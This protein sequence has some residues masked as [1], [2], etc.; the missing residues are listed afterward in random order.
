[1]ETEKI[2][3]GGNTPDPSTDTTINNVVN[4]HATPTGSTSPAIDHSQAELTKV[5][6]SLNIYFFTIIFLGLSFVGNLYILPI[7]THFPLQ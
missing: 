4:G 3:D 1:M 6:F 7:T 5:G 2:K